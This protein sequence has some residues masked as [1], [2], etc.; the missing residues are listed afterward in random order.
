MKIFKFNLFK[1]LAFKQPNTSMSSNVATTSDRS[2]AGIGYLADK[3]INIT[4]VG[5]IPSISSDCLYFLLL[6]LLVVVSCNLV[7]DI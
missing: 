4:D 5:S 2:N 1:R 3:M 6:R 7:N